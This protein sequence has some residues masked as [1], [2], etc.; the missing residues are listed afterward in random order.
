MCRRIGPKRVN[1]RRFSY[2]T[3]GLRVSLAPVAGDTKMPA[4][5][6][7]MRIL[8]ST[9]R[10]PGYPKGCAFTGSLHGY[11]APMDRAIEVRGLV[12]EF[13]GGIKAVA[14]ID[15]DVA[16][17]EIY[18]FL[19]PN[20]AGKSTTVHMLTTLLPPTA[21]TARVGGF[22]IVKQGPEVR[23][24]IGAA[25]QE[26]ALDPLLTGREH[27]KLQLALHGVPRDRRAARTDELL[28]RVGLRLAADRKI[29][30]YSGG[31]KR[32]L[33][34][35]L[36]LAH[37]PRILFL[38]EP[39]TG[40]DVQ[41]RSAL[42]DEVVRLKRE[43]GVTVFLTTQYLEEADVLA[44]R[45]GIIDHGRIVA[46]GT[47]AA[48]KNEIGLADDRSAARGRDRH[49]DARA[50]PVPLRRVTAVH[51][52]RGR[53]ARRPGRSRRCRPC[54]RRSRCARRGSPSP[55]TDARRRLPRQ[56]RPLAGVLRGGGTG[57][58]MSLASQVFH[59]GRRSL[60]RIL[61]QPANW[62]FPLVFPLAL[63]AVNTGG[64][65]AAT[66]LPGFPSDSFVAFF[67]AFP[68]IQGALF[69]TVNAGV[70]LARDIQ[71][72]FLNRL[73]LTPMQSAALLAGHL[74]GVIAVGAL[75]ALWYLTVGLA[76][77]VRFES[78]AAGALVIFVLAVLI[79]FAFGTFGALA[80]LRTGS[81]EAVHSLFPLFF[82]FL[83]ISSMNLPR[84]L[85]ETDWFRVAASLNPVSYLI[86]A[87]R[88]LV[89]EG[90]N[91]EALALGFGIAIAL[92]IVGLTLSSLALRGRM[93]RT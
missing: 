5:R 12:R 62:I 29:G 89:I 6:Q 75:Q 38:D 77:G 68:F 79:V 67:L 61:R 48:L 19:G 92:S 71:T 21:G 83:F 22:D 30:G 7:E 70:D 59:L 44:D 40:L 9:T 24:T 72:G 85:I 76:I 23:K 11:A 69:A 58:R 2:V 16:P 35:A 8:R 90:W 78:G 93:A 65:H 25:L 46:E 88:S 14:G 86:E 4:S 53:P 43:D 52:R 45:V 63:M 60:I 17:G 50:G 74:G 55:R 66:N 20:G 32:R 31:M 27:L 10:A 42:W 33:D 91:A 81:T 39:T 64:L 51:C 13:K 41:S 73:A 84:N 37:Y 80:A 3:P 56:D 49:R 57:A 87:I 82:V 47:P 28:E 36:A 1:C 26:A 54:A 18:G 15:L 34:L